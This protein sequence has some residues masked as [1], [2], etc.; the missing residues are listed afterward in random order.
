MIND[1]LNTIP[2]LQNAL[3]VAE[4]YLSALPKDTPYQ[5]FE[6]RSISNFSLSTSI[7]NIME[8]HLIRKT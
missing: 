1:T 8:N 7:L 4:V 2:K 3:K 6:A 5:N